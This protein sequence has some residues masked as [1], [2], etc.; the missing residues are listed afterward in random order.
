M[1]KSVHERR[2]LGTGAPCNVLVMKFWGQRARSGWLFRTAS[3][4]MMVCAG[5]GEYCERLSP[6]PTW[7]CAKANVTVHVERLGWKGQWAATES[8]QEVESRGVR[9]RSPCHRERRARAQLNLGRRALGL[10]N[11]SPVRF[12]PPPMIERCPP[13]APSHS[14]SQ[15]CFSARHYPLSTHTSPNAL[16]N[17]GQW[18]GSNPRR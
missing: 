9:P 6:A 13:R 14:D 1:L 5:Y 8:W 15:L 11:I 2:V 4:I 18:R 10:R 17:C 3:P 7:R 16:S 12:K